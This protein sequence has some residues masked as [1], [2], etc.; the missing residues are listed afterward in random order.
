[1]TYIKKDEINIKKQK[2]KD[3]YIVKYDLNKEVNCKAYFKMANNKREDVD[4][5]TI[6]E[7][8]LGYN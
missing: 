5:V 2:N 4:N 1:M 6:V 3:S 8:V 7:F